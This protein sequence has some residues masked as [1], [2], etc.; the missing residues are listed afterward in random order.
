V[1]VDLQRT[2]GKDILV[3]SMELVA[4]FVHGKTGYLPGDD[5]QLEYHHTDVGKLSKGEFLIY[6]EQLEPGIC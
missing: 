2:V 6:N 3:D 1:I 5:A 4:V